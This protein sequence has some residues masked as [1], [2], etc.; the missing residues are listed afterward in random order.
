[1]FYIWFGLFR[2]YKA[3]L[4]LHNYFKQNDIQFV[5]VE[6]AFPSKDYNKTG[7]KSDIMLLKV[8]NTLLHLKFLQ[9]IPRFFFVIVICMCPIK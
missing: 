9:L 6:Q 3:F 8:K 2:S 1:M 4:G 5:F 7:Y